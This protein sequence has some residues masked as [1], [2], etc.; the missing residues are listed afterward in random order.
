MIFKNFILFSLYLKKVW[1]ILTYNCGKKIWEVGMHR[2][3]LQ[4]KKKKKRKTLAVTQSS[5]VS[6]SSIN[7]QSSSQ[8]I[9]SPSLNPP[10]YSEFQCEVIKT[11]NS[12]S[13]IRN[14]N[15][16]NIK[17]TNASNGQGQSF[18]SGVGVDEPKVEF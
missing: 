4:L 7:N 9:L 2:R 17:N 10:Q 12:T 3:L 16:I 18:S 6:I 8:S 1:C 14:S 13:S 11:Y 5:W 15:K